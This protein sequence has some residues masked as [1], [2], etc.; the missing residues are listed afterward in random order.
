[1]VLHE[2]NP[3]NGPPPAAADPALHAPA[4][5]GLVPYAGHVHGLPG[6]IC[7]QDV[8]AQPAV[9]QET[10]HFHRLPLGGCVQRGADVVRE[11]AVGACGHAPDEGP[12]AL[13][14]WFL[15]FCVSPREV[16]G[17]S[18]DEC[19]HTQKRQLPIKLCG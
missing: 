2:S 18:V 10:P 12:Q 9:G 16:E 19:L 14:F 8:K 6:R 15:L 13:T 1:M 5:H 3:A 11:Q 17:R 4:Q 7:G